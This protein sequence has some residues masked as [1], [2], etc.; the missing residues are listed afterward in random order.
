MCRWAGVPNQ[1]VV[2]WASQAQVADQFR[3]VS[4]PGIPLVCTTWLKQRAETEVPKGWICL[5]TLS[6]KP[7]PPAAASRVS[8]WW[9]FFESSL[10]GSGRVI[11]P[12][13]GIQRTSISEFGVLARLWAE[14]I[15]MP[16]LDTAS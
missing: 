8:A 6:S 11:L 14:R 9:Y 16:S 4:L 15:E 2:R 3:E 7:S 5:N 12:P 13:V 1:H 10:T